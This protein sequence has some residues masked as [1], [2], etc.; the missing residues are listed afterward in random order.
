MHTTTTANPPRPRSTI[1]DLL[2]IAAKTPTLLLAGLLTA[3]I[4]MQWIHPSPC[5]LVTIVK[6]TPEGET[7]LLPLSATPWISDYADGHGLLALEGKYLKAVFPTKAISLPI[8]TSD[9]YA[10]HPATVSQSQWLEIDLHSLVGRG[11]CVVTLYDDGAAPTE[12]VEA[13]DELVALFRSQGL[14]GFEATNPGLDDTITPAGF[15]EALQGFP[16]PFVEAICTLAG[17]IDFL[18]GHFAHLA[19]AGQEE[20][21]FKLCDEISKACIGALLPGIRALAFH[22]FG[23]PVL[24]PADAKCFLSKVRHAQSVSVESV[25]SLHGDLDPQQ[26]QELLSFLSKAGI[27]SMEGGLV[28]VVEV[29][30]FFATKVRGLTGTKDG[31]PSALLA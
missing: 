1:D 15:I 24:N 5:P 22:G 18:V 17:E 19:G 28:S 13:V 23:W 4:Q 3:R 2:E 29:A 14:R 16:E 8:E 21:E 25:A 7:V 27:I 6:D 26:R 12:S 20:E 31:G 11:Q 9:L 10:L 30:D